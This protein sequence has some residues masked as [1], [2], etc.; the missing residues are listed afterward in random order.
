ME[1]KSIQYNKIDDTHY[2]IDY[3]GGCHLTLSAT[4]NKQKT[5]ETVIDMLLMPQIDEEIL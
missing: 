3:D 4:C 5:I 2:L 1:Y